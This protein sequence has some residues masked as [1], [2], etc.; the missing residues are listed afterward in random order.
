MPNS[1]TPLMV[2]LNN[3]NVGIGTTSPN[4]ELDVNG[5]VN[6]SNYYTYSD[7]RFKK[8]IEP[9]Q[10]S[11]NEV[12][13]L[14]PVKYNWKVKDFPDKN[15]DEKRHIGLIAQ[16]VE[17]IFPELVNTDKEGYKHVDYA[18]FV[19]ILVKAIQELNERIENLEKQN[20]EL[21]NLSIELKAQIKQMQNAGIK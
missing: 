16:D 12:L 3:G 7:I 19:P 18:N 20:K 13:K 8:D 14:K 2:I 15:F 11:I 21:E 1:E 6:A 5:N 9:I 17:K 4:Y 10:T